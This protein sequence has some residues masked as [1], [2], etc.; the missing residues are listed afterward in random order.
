MGKRI[1][2]LRTILLL[3]LMWPFFGIHATPLLEFDAKPEALERYAGKGKWLVVMVWASDCLICNKE[4]KEYDRLHQQRHNKDI[5]VLGISM[6]GRSNKAAAEAFIKQHELHF[7]NLL[8]EPEDVAVMF[9]DLT[10]EQWAGTPSFLIYS[11]AGKL[12]VQQ[13]GAVPVPLIEEFI[14]KQAQPTS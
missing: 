3:G 4:V 12:M 1:K 9:Y 13:I 10:G 7:T 2:C 14:R 6:D 8:A 11:P 5:T